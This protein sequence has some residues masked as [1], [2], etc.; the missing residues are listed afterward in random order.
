M[1]KAPVILVRFQR[2]LTVLDKLS[3]NTQISHFTKIRPPPVVLELF[4]ADRRMERHDE[5][6]SRFSQFCERE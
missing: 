2:N 5:K 1:Y 3:K 4:N 6:L